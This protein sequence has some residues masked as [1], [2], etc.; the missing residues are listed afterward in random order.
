MIKES[1]FK[2]HFEILYLCKIKDPLGHVKKGVA[3]SNADY[4][5]KD[6]YPETYT[7]LFLSSF[8]LGYTCP[9][10]LKNNSF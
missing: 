3:V 2:K 7:K 8:I 10:L 1:L 4:C 6:I 5:C 9:T